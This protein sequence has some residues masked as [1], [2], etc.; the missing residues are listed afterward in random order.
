[1]K[2]MVDTIAKNTLYKKST[3]CKILTKN[4]IS[5]HFVVDEE[6]LII[7]YKNTDY[8]NTKSASLRFYIEDLLP[9]I[10]EKII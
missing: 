4:N 5:N 6:E 7:L 2:V 1:M 3:I 8:K 9:D 10:T